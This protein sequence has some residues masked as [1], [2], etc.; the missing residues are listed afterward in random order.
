M[1]TF[2]YCP[3]CA[4]PLERARHGDAERIACPDRAC[5]YVHWDNPVPVVAAIV[6][7]DGDIV[8]ARNAAWPPDFFALI[9]GFL[10]KHDPHPESGVLREVAEELGLRGRIGEFIGFY[11]FERMNQIILAYHVIAEGEIRLNEELVE[12][13]KQPLAEIR[14]WPAG[15]GYAVRDLQL[16]RGLTPPPFDL[17]ML[18]RPRAWREIEPTLF[19]SG[20]PTADEFKALRAIG[21]ETVI[22][23]ALPTSTH[24]LPDEDDVLRALGLRYVHIPVVFEAPTADD[25]ARFCAAMADS[26]GQTR[27]V[28]CALNMRV[29]AFLFLWRIIVRGVPRE[30]AERD[31]LA[32][33]TPDAVWSAF[34]ER[35]LAAAGPR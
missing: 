21:V 25:F 26:E 4:R 32:I 18:R 2:K 29:S 6:E 5:G 23:L 22:N 20:Q 27:L 14:P 9:T 30:I 35:T 16:R 15:T 17:R 28:H 1:P 12:W 34:I 13:K 7:H 31:L 24:A 11:P 19:T 8:L 33:W 3:Q 10:E